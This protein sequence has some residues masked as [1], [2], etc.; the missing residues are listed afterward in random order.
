MK[1][2]ADA[3]GTKLPPLSDINLM[4]ASNSLAAKRHQPLPFA[5]IPQLPAT[6]EVFGIRYAEHRLFK[7][8]CCGLL[9]LATRLHSP[10]LV[11]LQWVKGWTQTSASSY[12][13]SD[14]VSCQGRLHPGLQQHTSF[15]QS[16]ALSAV[17]QPLHSQLPHSLLHLSPLLPHH[18]KCSLSR[19]QFWQA[20]KAILS[21]WRPSW[22]PI[23]HCALWQCSSC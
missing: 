1:R 17:Q 22:L 10:L 19:R 4:L 2:A 8:R 16:F 20:C 11:C 13:A 23:Q 12:S 7:R 15:R 21:C 18:S 3:A 9:M 14:A 5:H 6:E